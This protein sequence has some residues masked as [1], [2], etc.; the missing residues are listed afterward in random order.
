MKQGFTLIELLVVVLIIGILSAVALPQYAKAVEKARASEA[1]VILKSIADANKAYYMANGVY[2]DHLDQLDVEIP[3]EDKVFNGWNRKQS[4]NYQFGTRA[5]SI[6]DSIAL[7]NRLPFGTVYFMYVMPDV[8]G[9]FCKGYTAAGTETCKSL[10]NGNKEG[11]L[12]I[13]R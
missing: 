13:I 3:G 2:A 7:A 12:Y 4:K 11:D 9:T 6:N 5:Q 8:A 1:L 10:S